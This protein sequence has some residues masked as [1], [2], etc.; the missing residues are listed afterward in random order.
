VRKRRSS[1]AWVAIFRPAFFRARALACDLFSAMVPAASG[2]LFRPTLLLLPQNHTGAPIGRLFRTVLAFSA[3][4]AVLSVPNTARGQEIPLEHCDALLVIQ[5]QAGGR[6]SWFLVDTAATSMLNLESFAGEPR[7]DI[8]VTSWKGTFTTSARE[9]K[10]TE[11]VVGRTKLMR[12][13]LPAIDLSEIGKACGKKL[14]GILG[15]DL[16]RKIGA[17][18]DLKRAS[19]HVTTADEQHDA[20]LVSEM[21]MDTERCEKAF[22]DSDE[23]TFADCLDPKITLFTANEELSGR[24]KAT[25]YFRDSYFH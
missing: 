13:T 14:D 5:V 16:L 11:L 4:L 21:Q 20:E 23:D 19:L 8:R 3:L 7:R 2:P 6:P 24:E 15:V 17:T 1:N 12:L 22:N 18:I 9:V 25:G 10:L